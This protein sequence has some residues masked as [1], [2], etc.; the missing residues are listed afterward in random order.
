MG[1]PATVLEY[2]F[3]KLKEERDFYGQIAKDL[4][5]RGLINMES[6]H[7]IMSQQDLFAS[8]TTEMG[9]QFLKFITSPVGSNDK[10]EQE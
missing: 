4:S 7:V 10:K 5:I 1:T 3:P 6:L 2:A 8:R 9:K